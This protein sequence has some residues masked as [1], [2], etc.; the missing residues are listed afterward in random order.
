LHFYPL[1]GRVAAW[2][3]GMPSA[4]S[5]TTNA[6]ADRE[7][8]APSEV[9]FARWAV[10]KWRRYGADT[11]G[12]ELKQRVVSCLLRS[13]RYH[14]ASEGAGLAGFVANAV[15]ERSDVDD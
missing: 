2:P 4:L 6:L 11:L 14:C 15:T 8:Q 10:V 5:Q 9:F 7:P 13:V 3:P 12:T 1:C